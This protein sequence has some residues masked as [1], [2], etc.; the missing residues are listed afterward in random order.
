MSAPKPVKAPGHK[1]R[2]IYAAKFVCECGA[3]GVHW[4]GKG[5]A[6]NARAEHR[7]HMERCAANATGGA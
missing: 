7:S 2:L 6:R 3:E 1:S 4:Y 5:A